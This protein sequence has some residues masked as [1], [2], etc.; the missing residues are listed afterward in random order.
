MPMAQ[1]ILQQTS[2]QKTPF[3]ELPKEPPMIKPISQHVQCAERV[4]RLEADTL[5]ALIETLDESF[6][7]T[8]ETLAKATGRVIVSGMG[9]NG[10]IGCKIAATLASTGT[11]AQFVHPAEA[12]HGDLGM[13]TEKDAVLALSNSGET[14]ELSDL[15][16]YTRRFAI[17]LICI[18]SKADSTLAKASDIALILP[19]MREACPNGQAPT[20]STTATLALGDAIAIALLEHKGFSAEDFGIFH[21]GGKLGKQLL[22]VSELMHP[23]QHTPIVSPTTIMGDALIIMAEK[24]FGCLAVTENEKLLGIITDGDLRRNMAGDLPNKQAKDIMTTSP[25]TLSKDML[26]AEA[27]AVMNSKKISV[28][29]IVDQQQNLQGVIHIHDLLRAGIL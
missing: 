28:M 19:P 1:E 5:H 23:I 6:D 17:P 9:K 29:F 11:T 4:I 12:S 26:A 10:H 24:N 8:I 7:K 14:T 21:P 22:K 25:Q 3:K 20:T 18:T 13:I 15:I 27:L 16:A 2:P